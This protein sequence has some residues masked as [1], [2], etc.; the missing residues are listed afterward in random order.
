MIYWIK[1]RL[2]PRRLCKEKLAKVFGGCDFLW[3]R[4]RKCLTIR[5][6]ERSIQIWFFIQTASFLDS[7]SLK[8]LATRRRLRKSNFYL[9]KINQVDRFQFIR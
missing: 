5:Y 4:A 1:K 6:I 7:R 9:V 2:L 8:V 3:E